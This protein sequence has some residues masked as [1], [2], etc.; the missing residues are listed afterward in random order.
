M[1]QSDGPAGP[2]ARLRELGVRPGVL[3]PGPLN[4]ITDV[5]GA[6][7]GHLSLVEGDDIRTGVT[8]IL[9]HGENLFQ[10]RVPAGLAVGNGFGKLAGAT[11]LAELGELE[12]PIVLTNTLAVPRAADAL[13]SYTLGQPGNAA[14]RSV[15]PVVGECNDAML[16]DIRRRAVTP[17]HV[18]AA[19]AARHPHRPRRGHAGDDPGR[20]GHTGPQGSGLREPVRRAEARPLHPR[21]RRPIPGGGQHSRRRLHDGR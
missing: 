16:N 9:P 12:T 3:R 14:V 17:E 18:L 8:A 2:R 10:S 19:I 1:S 11:Q 6:R 21:G 15:N 4:A 7:V 20:P 5:A 13:I